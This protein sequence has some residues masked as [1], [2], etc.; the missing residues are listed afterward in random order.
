VNIWDEP[1]EGNIVRDAKTGAIRAGTLNQLVANLAS[2][3]R[4][5]T[6][7]RPLF[8][9]HCSHD[10]RHTHTRMMNAD[11]TYVD[12]FLMTYKTFTTPHMLL[13][14]LLQRYTVPVEHEPDVRCVISLP[15]RLSPVSTLLI[16]LS[17][18][19]H[20]HRTHRSTIQ[21]Y[22]VNVLKKW[23]QL[24]RADFDK[25]MLDRLA[26]LCQYTVRAPFYVLRKFL[27]IYDV[28]V[29]LGACALFVWEPHRRR[30]WDPATTEVS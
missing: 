5:G 22:T 30:R 25:D 21:L 7:I 20:T 29:Y 18:H 14:K 9:W 11:H 2:Q 28:L 1:A 17:A 27:D 13:E 4:M 15:C 26:E 6:R 16:H 19:A 24:Y 23:L 12:S 10:A 3:Q 8:L